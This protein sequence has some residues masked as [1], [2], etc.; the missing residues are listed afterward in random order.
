MNTASFWHVTVLS[1]F[2]RAYN[3]YSRLYS[4]ESLAKSTYP[5]RFFLLQEGE[6]TIGIRKAGSFLARLAIPGNLLIALRTSVPIAEIQPNTHNGLGQYIHGPAIRVDSIAFIEE[7]E[8]TVHLQPVA[9]EEAIALSFQLL[10][11]ELHDYQEIKPRSFSIL[12]IA[13]G[14]QASCPFCFSEAS[15]SAEQEQARL[16]LT[17]LQHF[18]GEAR[19]RGAERFVITGGGEPGLV[20]HELLRKIMEIGRDTFG[21]TVLIT[22]GHHLATKS[23]AQ[24]A[25]HLADYAASGLNVL[26]VSRHHHDDDASE[27]LMSLRTH[28]AS[29]AQAWSSERE[30]WPSLRMRFTC[31]LQRGYVDSMDTFTEYVNWA[32]QLGV[33]EL[34]FKELY[35]STSIES[36]YHRHAANEWSH[37]NQVPLSLVLDFAARHGFTEVDR[38]PWG[39]PVFRGIWNGRPMQIAAY[40][41]P[42]LLWERTHGIARSWNQMSDGRCLASLEDRA[43]EIHLP[44]TA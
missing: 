1:N 8:G 28:V 42:S 43:S 41:E 6:L 40:T 5:D 33:P 21:K 26:A 3:K 18:A 10:T 36:V 16:D 9:V 35:V 25:S 37:A 38:L 22:N 39:S 15:A 32:A 12:P 2:A 13:R 7:N 27:K 20:R 44:V 34:C 31:V 4:K 30:R 23:P 29:I 19:A 17:H 14:C 24:I 11:A